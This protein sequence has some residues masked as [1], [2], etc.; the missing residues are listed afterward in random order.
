MNFVNTSSDSHPLRKDINEFL[1]TLH[2]F[3]IFWLNLVYKHLHTVQFSNRQLRKIRF[4]D[5][6]TSL[7]NVK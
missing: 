7:K 4:N 3:E 5:S 1:P 2:T 6:H